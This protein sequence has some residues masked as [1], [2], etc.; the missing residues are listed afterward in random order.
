MLIKQ[1]IVCPFC[2]S[3]HTEVLLTEIAVGGLRI[4]MICSKCD[5]IWN[6]NFKT[7]YMGYDYR[8]E[9]DIFHEVKA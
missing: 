2:H 9:N 4:E 8:D 6:E 3:E 5:K 1:P 7:S